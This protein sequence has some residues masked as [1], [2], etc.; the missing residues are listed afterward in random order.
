MKYLNFKPLDIVDTTG[1][2][3]SAIIDLSQI[4]KISVQIV[5]GAGTT[6]AG[7]VQLQVSND[8]LNAGY[9]NLNAPTHWSNLGTATALSA[10]STNYLIGQQDVCYRSLKIVFTGDPSNDAPVS[11]NV[12]ALAF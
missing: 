11:I 7:S 6:M 5:V 4:Y 10:A 1:N 12:M 2:T 8:E 9:M 3:D